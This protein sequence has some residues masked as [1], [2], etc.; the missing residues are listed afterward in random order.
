MR[1]RG[2]GCAACRHTGYRGRT[3]VFELLVVSEEIKQALLKSP[4][5]GALREIA[6][7]QGMTTLRQDGWRKVQAGVNTVGEGLCVAETRTG[8]IHAGRA[9][10][11]GHPDFGSCRA[12][13]AACV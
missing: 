9:P 13:R 1:E 4:S 10:P 7:A 8:R 2:R 3:G 5:G 6:Q 12:P 11:C